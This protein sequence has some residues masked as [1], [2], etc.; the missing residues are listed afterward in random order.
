MAGKILSAAGRSFWE[1]S[2]ICRST[3][4]EFL[5]QRQL[6]W[7]APRVEYKTPWM[8]VVTAKVLDE[9]LTEAEAIKALS[10]GVAFRSEI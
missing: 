2:Q 7:S 5:E 4:L 3:S 6:L 1:L 10:N 9:S 8:P